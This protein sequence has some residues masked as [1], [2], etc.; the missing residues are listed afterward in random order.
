MVVI[1]KMKLIKIEEWGSFPVGK[2]FDIH[3][4]KAYKLTNSS[5]MEE[6]GVNPVVVNSSLPKCLSNFPYFTGFPVHSLVK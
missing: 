3:P 6:D 2:L 1:K 5:L 4:T